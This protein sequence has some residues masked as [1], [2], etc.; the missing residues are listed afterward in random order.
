LFGL[1]VLLAVPLFFGL[2]RGHIIAGS[3]VEEGGRA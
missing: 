3:V 1:N 2:D